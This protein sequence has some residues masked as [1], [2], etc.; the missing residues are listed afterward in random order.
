MRDSIVMSGTRIGR[1]CRIEKGIVAENVEIGDN[2]IFSVGEYAESALNPKVYAF[3]LVTVAENSV[4]PS[5]VQIGKNTAIVGITA[6]EDYP[7][8][9]LASGQAIVKAGEM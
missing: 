3:D 6:A 4:I 7:D 1:N 9:L 5:N 2:V 8:G